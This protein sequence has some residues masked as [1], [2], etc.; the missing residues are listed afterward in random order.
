MGIVALA[1][2]ITITVVLNVPLRRPIAESLLV[3]L[4]GTAPVGGTRVFELLGLGV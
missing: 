3:A 4:I 1:V 2:F